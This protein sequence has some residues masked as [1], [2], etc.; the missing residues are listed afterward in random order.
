MSTTNIHK[1]L[2]YIFDI[3]RL[4]AWSVAEDKTTMVQIPSIEKSILEKK[5]L[6]QGHLHIFCSP[7]VK[8]PQQEHS[9]RVEP[10]DGPQPSRV[11]EVFLGR[12]PAGRA[13]KYGHVLHLRME[14]TLTELPENSE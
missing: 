3:L 9:E 8:H 2:K 11:G 6:I 5:N 12:H 10:K 7:E 4:Y 1:N 13:L 14:T